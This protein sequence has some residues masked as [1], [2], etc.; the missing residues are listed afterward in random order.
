MR[1]LITLM[2]LV[3]TLC[4]SD[5]A[6]I[7]VLSPLGTK[8]H[9]NSLLPIVETLAERG[10]NI[11]I[12]TAHTAKTT[13]SNIRNINFPELVKLI[14][15]DAGQQIGDINPLSIAASILEEMRTLLTVA[16]KVLMNNKYV[17]EILEEPR[18]FDLAIVDATM[19]EFTLPLVDHLK[20]PFIFQ[21]AASVSP[22]T[23]RAFNIPPE[24]ASL[25]PLML[26]NK[27][28]DI[29]LWRRMQHMLAV[30]IFLALRNWF[31]LPRIDEL[32]RQDFP[33]GRS[34]AEIE[35]SSELCLSAFD[36]VT[37]WPR[38]FPAT[39]IP[40]GPTHVRPAKQLAKVKGPML[41][42]FSASHRPNDLFW[43]RIFLKGI[44]N[45]G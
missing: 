37:A 20:L 14:D 41:L 31:V 19:N 5:S 32:A 13:H 21:S 17:R 1:L 12:L 26:D 10:H 9:V 43:L 22:W 2:I 40:I 18:P 34:V 15:D 39:F 3:R 29:N 24:Y 11:T 28:G 7:L 6:R 8:S 25:P 42:G 4:V 38:P 44:S 36:V 33:A 23:M 35:R 30:E 45:T 16:Y 27:S